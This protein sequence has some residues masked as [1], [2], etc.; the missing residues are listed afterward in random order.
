MNLAPTTSPATSVDAAVINADAGN[1]PADPSQFPATE[2]Q[3]EIWLSSKQSVEANCA[4]NEIASI[5]FRGELDESALKQAWTAVVKRHSALRATFSDDGQTMIIGEMPDPAWKRVDWSELDEPDREIERLKLVQ[6]EACVPF[7]LE[8]GPLIRAVLQRIADQEFCFTISA[9]HIVLDGWSLGVV[10]GDLGRLYDQIRSGAVAELEPADDYR[11][12]SAAMDRYFNSVDAAQDEAF[13]LEQWSG[14]IPILDLPCDQPRPTERTW[15]ARRYDH[16]LSAELVEQIRKLGARSGCSIF[17]TM[18]AAFESFVARISGCHEFGI[19]IPTA[20][21]LAMDHSQLVGH[22]VNTMPLRSSVDVQNS[23]NDQLKKS[24]TRLL[25]ALDHQRYSFGKLLGKLAP[26]RDPSR[27]PLLAVSFN[28]DPAADPEESGFS[29]LETKAIVEPRM[30]ENFEWFINGIVHQ[31]QSIELQVQYNIDLYSAAM[32]KSLFAGFEG[33]LRSLAGD[34]E[35]KIAE[36]PVLNLTQQQKILVEFNTTEQPL[37]EYSTLHEWISAQALKTP[38]RIAVR[39][40]DRELNYA[41]LESGANRL[42]QQLT[43]AGLKTGELAG[44]CVDRSEQMLIAILGVLKTGAGYVPLDPAFPLDRLQYMCDQSRL[45]LIV[46]DESVRKTVESFGVKTHFVE[47]AN[48]QSTNEHLLQKS[49][50]DV[51]DTCYVIYT[52]GSTGDPKGVQIPHGAVINFLHSMAQSPGFGADDSVLAVTTLSFDI[53]VLELFLPLTVGGTTVIATKEM[54]SDG[55]L[56]GQALED[57]DISLLQSTPAMLRLMIE[58]GWEGKSD[59]KILCGG[60]PMPGDIVNPVSERCGEF[61]NMYGPTETTVWSTIWRVTDPNARIMIGKPIANTQVYLLDANGMPVPF[62]C[63]GEIYIGGAGVTLGYLHQAELTE[64]R[65]VDNRWFNPFQSYCNYRLYR[66]GDLGRMSADGNIE[67][68][69]RNDKQVKVR[70]FRIELGEIESRINSM[71]GVAS[72]VAIVRED[73]PGDTRLAAYWVGNSQFPT[74]CE[75]IRTTLREQLPYYMVPQHV[76]ELDQFPE[77]N[78]RKI[79]YKA[80]PAPGTNEKNAPVQPRTPTTAAERLVAEI[81]SDTLE[82]SDIELD[83]NFFDLGGHSLLVMKVITRIES[84]C[85]ARLSP[86]EFLVSTLE[87]IADFVEQ[88]GEGLIEEVDEI[89]DEAAPNEPSPAGLQVEKKSLVGRIAGFWD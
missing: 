28:I 74:T 56:I 62:G 5:E 67:F 54:T 41:E 43:A 55:R 4:Y 58:S 87:Q 50:S 37:P 40:E 35:R 39:F 72:S 71:P 16:V 34:G 3:L 84:R 53:A 47:Q 79:D 26:P 32:M 65:F 77:T 51:S 2:A 1:L 44:V 24:R 78:S 81:W 15:F 64:Q 73:S 31:D 85:G 30:F 42:S 13:W 29:G 48:G 12:Y 70:G 63:E 10:I 86:P 9:H 45:Q 21:Q 59:L 88:N 49:A 27:P 8:K 18:L 23:F 20:G 19:G 76:I 57:H 7:E 52:S 22:C 82:V 46:A 68:L 83:D 25:D 33:F 75:Q 36:L 69:R 61:W 80:L 66:T 6:A 89:S 17:N 60:E 14:E 11:S 38:D